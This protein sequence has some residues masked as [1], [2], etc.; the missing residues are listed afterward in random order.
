MVQTAHPAHAL[1]LSPACV[2]LP[3]LL[4]SLPTAT[5]HAPS[6]LP[7]A[8]SSNAAAARTRFARA[9]AGRQFD[10]L[11][12]MRATQAAA[13]L[14]ETCDD[15]PT[16]EARKN[17]RLLMLALASATQAP[18]ACCLN[19]RPHFGSRRRRPCWSFLYVTDPGYLT[20]WRIRSLGAMPRCAPTAQLHNGP[21]FEFTQAPFHC[22]QGPGTCITAES[23]DNEN[24]LNFMLLR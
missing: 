10:E 11:A 7:P 1:A 21:H 2:L 20:F 8:S 14:G 19:P 15:A 24:I 4:R 12:S 23:W 9:S 13:S 3:S 5:S 18:V 22:L 6:R 16:N 17:V